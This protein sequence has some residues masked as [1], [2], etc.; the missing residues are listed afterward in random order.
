MGKTPYVDAQ[1]AISAEW[2]N[3]ADT[4]MHDDAGEQLL[5]SRSH[6]VAWATYTIDAAGALI[7]VVENHGFTSI[8]IQPDGKIHYLVLASTRPDLNGGG[9]QSNLFPMSV[10]QSFIKG[11]W[12]TAKSEKLADNSERVLIQ[13]EDASGA[14]VTPNVARTMNVVVFGYQ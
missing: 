7:E 12:A 4:H 3:K 6:A 14:F 10:T 9:V 2:L 1:T 13:F 11:A 8:T 5:G